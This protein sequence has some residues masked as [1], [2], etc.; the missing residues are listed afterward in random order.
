VAASQR[1][2]AAVPALGSSALEIEAM[3]TMGVNPSH[4][5]QHPG[6]YYYMAAKCTEARRERFLAAA[7]AEVC[8][9]YS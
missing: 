9:V 1:A 5:L 4:A 6:Y 2:A 7:E 8:S 3:R